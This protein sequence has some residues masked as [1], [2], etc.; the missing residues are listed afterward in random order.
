MNFPPRRWVGG[1]AAA[2]LLALVLHNILWLELNQRTIPCNYSECDPTVVS[3]DHKIRE[4][5]PKAPAVFSWVSPKHWDRPCGYS[6]C[7]QP[8]EIDK[9]AAL[10][11]HRV[12]RGRTQIYYYLAQRIPNATLTVPAWMADT[13]WYLERVARLH[14]KVAGSSLLVAPEKVDNLRRQATASRRWFRRGPR[15]LRK[16]VWQ[17]MYFL[18]RDGVTDYVLAETD[19]PGGP[20]FVL[21]AS[22]FREVDSRRGK[23]P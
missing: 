19:K 4:T 20:L 23:R 9:V 15:R 1:C 11:V 6:V 3:V 18:F 17:E 7:A 14:V 13:K 8:R 22:R 21:P 12:V 16:Q 10:N 5:Q 2:V